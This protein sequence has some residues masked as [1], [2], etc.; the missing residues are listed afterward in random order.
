MRH[1]T[2]GTKLKEYKKI[3]INSI[4]KMI[5]PKFSKIK[6]KIKVNVKSFMM[7]KNPTKSNKHRM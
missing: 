4:I 5:P 6:K 3:K 2:L 1:S 7:N